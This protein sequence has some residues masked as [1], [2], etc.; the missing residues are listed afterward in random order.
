MKGWFL[1]KALSRGLKGF[2]VLTHFAD[3]GLLPP[4]VPPLTGYVSDPLGSCVTKG[5]KGVSW[6]RTH[7]ASY[8]AF[9]TPSFKR[10]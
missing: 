5:R 3:T 1:D 7:S 9:V 10:P 4:G 2:R 8:W 6:K